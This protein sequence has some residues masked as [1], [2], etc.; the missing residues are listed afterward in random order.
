MHIT[1]WIFVEGWPV[2]SLLWGNSELCLVFSP[3]PH[4]SIRLR[5]TFSEGHFRVL[6]C[7]LFHI[8][9][10]SKSSGE[11]L[12][13][14][15]SL[16]NT[17]P[18]STYFHALPHGLVALSRMFLLLLDGTGLTVEC[19]RVQRV[20]M[21]QNHLGSHQPTCWLSFAALVGTSFSALGG[22]IGLLCFMV[23]SNLIQFLE[24]SL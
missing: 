9:L 19:L 11:P 22:I 12:L 7:C 16:I 15:L 23:P 2:Q 18:V 5:K 13:S 21:E 8:H 1:F 3:W 10:R 20:Q 6:S 24:M 14:W 4:C 17:F